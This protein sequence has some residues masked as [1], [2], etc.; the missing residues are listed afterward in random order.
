A[1]IGL[2][3]LPKLRRER[4]R[5][6]VQRR[7]YAV[8]GLV[9]G[10]TRGFDQIQLPEERQPGGMRAGRDHR[11]ERKT[12]ILDM[13]IERLVI[14]DLLPGTGALGA[15]QK[16]EGIG[17]VDSHEG[18]RRIENVGTGLELEQARPKRLRQRCVLRVIGQEDAHDYLE[19]LCA[20]DNREAATLYN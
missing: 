7:K 16:Q 15:K 20:R 19:R 5:F 10:H 1:A 14:L 18:N 12:L 13:A 4:L 9:F 2:D 6:T 3:E 8:N 11:H 17:L